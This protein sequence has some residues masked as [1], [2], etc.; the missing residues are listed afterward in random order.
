MNVLVVVGVTLLLLAIIVPAILNARDAARMTQSRNNLKQVGLAFHNYHDVYSCFPLGAGA[1]SNGDAT[2][3]WTLGILPCLDQSSF[4]SMV[5]ANFPWDHPVNEYLFQQILPHA[6]D[7]P[8]AKATRTSEGYGLTHYMANPNVCHRRS[9]VSISQMTS[10]TSNNWLCG[11]VSGNYQPWGYP[12]NWRPLSLPFNSGPNSY[13]RPTGEGTQ[14]CFADGSVRLLANAVSGEVVDAL[15]TAPPVAAN[16]DTSVPDRHFVTGAF[17]APRIDTVPLGE[18]QD[19]RKPKFYAF[20]RFDSNDGPETATFS[21]P[22]KGDEAIET[23]AHI[24]LLQ[25]KYPKLRHLVARRW[26]ISDS[27]AQILQGF[28]QLQTLHVSKIEITRPG[29]QQLQSL[30]QLTTLVGSATEEQAAAIAEELPDVEFFR[31]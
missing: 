8:G 15:K 25:K 27:D 17:A 24:A 11:E 2:H 23:S 28:S 20:V 6:F 7:M 19:P 16:E 4:Y 18:S 12:F 14:I 13:G 10:G 26:S 1:N 5:D 3:G 22:S 31:R 9:C 21:W 30:T 29:L